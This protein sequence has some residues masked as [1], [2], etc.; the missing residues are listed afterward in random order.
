MSAPTITAPAETNCYRIERVPVIWFDFGGVLSPPLPDLFAAWE[1]KTGISQ[2]HMQAAFAA[3]ADAHGVDALAP[4]ELAQMKE[5]EWGHEIS[6][7]L[8]TLYPDLNQSRARWGEF[9]RQWFDGIEPS[10]GPM[11]LLDACR[12]WGFRVAILSNNVAE[13]EP[14]WHSIIAAAGPLDALIDSC[15]VG[16]RKPDPEIFAIAEQTVGAAA[17]EC[18][19]VD[20]LAI[21]CIA[22]E[23]R[24]WRAIHYTTDTDLASRLSLLTGMPR[25]F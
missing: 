20:D 13:W 7:S 21:N 1:V 23:R 17:D 15:R 14:Y 4:I 24:G 6:R 19:L 3:F 25:V 2:L 18:L 22:A 8:G 10:R 11:R 12:S 16:F 5:A 9:G